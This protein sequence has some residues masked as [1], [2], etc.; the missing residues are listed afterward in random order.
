MRRLLKI[1]AI[2]AVVLVVAIGAI[3]VFLPTERISQ[4]AVDQVKSATG[5]DLMLSGGVSPS[6]Y[7]VLG[8]ETGAVTL[9]N[10]EW[11]S[12]PNMVS[13]SSAKIGVELMPLLSG[14][15]RITEIRLIDPIIDLEINEDGA[16]NW[17]FQPLEAAAEATVTETE[18][19]AEAD[20]EGGFVKDISLGET[21]IQNGAVNFTDRTSGQ[22]ISIAEINAAIALPAF[23]QEMTVSGSALWNGEETS[24][25]LK[26]ST[27]ATILAGAETEVSLTAGAA[28]VSVEFAGAF[29][30]PTASSPPE[31]AGTFKL[32]ASNPAA[33]AQWATGDA[34]PVG[35]AGLAD[36][37][38]NGEIAM[39]STVIA[40]KV[41]GGLTR[42]GRRATVDVSVQ[43]DAEW[44]TS[45]AFDVNAKAALDGLADASFIGKIAAPDGGAP[46]GS[47]N[48]VVNAPDIKGL[49][50]FAGAD[51][52]KMG[53][54]A[55]QSFQASGALTLANPSKIALDLKV[56]AIDAIT[57]SGTVSAD[58]AGTPSITANLDTGALDLTPY[59]TEGGQSTGGGE[60]GWSKTPID[61]SALGTVNGDFKIRAASVKAPQLT[62]GKSDIRAVLANGALQ[63]NIQELGLYG[64]GL[65]GD[66]ALD[67]RNDNAVKANVSAAT[68]RLLPMLKDVAG[69]EMV[70]G[71]G[72][73]N[74]NV[75]GG[76]QS[77]HDI[78]NSLDG[79]GG[80]KLTDGALVGYDLA[81]MIQNVKSAFGGG[82][83]N[84]AKTSFSE[85][86]AT[87]DIEN[88][89]MT[90]ADFAFLGPLIRIV[91]QGTVDL[92]G[93]LVNF[94]LTPK[95]VS[96]LKGQGGSLDDKGLSFPL[97]IKGPWSS[98]SIRPDLKAGIDSLLK[99][100]EGAVNAAKDIVKG[101]K[102]GGGVKGAV[103][104]LTGG[105]SGGVGGLLGGGNADGEAETA[106][107]DAV[108][109]VLKGLFGKK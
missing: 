95:A 93:Q 45:R 57:A 86:S 19:D 62:L 106:P 26:V 77:L 40:V 75:R 52:P 99:D 6:F 11:G 29:A 97:I 104:A 59:V 24:L 61:L 92:G 73:V 41:Q 27:L 72:A 103:E 49:A 65:K 89:V 96:S 100:P 5:R 71:L 53:P 48:F 63:L 60:P 16:A 69:M 91:G 36:L 82:A 54:N 37:D 80:M 68:V 88:G 90:N 8:V 81:A 70:E 38:L 66:I 12:A 47:G 32:S 87:F 43:G 39:D 101:V 64:G 23:D 22:N 74:I 21:T 17:E 94:R 84:D 42:D 13:A 102:D 15:V 51:L 9:S 18:Q 31:V 4:I 35:L 30:P 33:A 98:P 20:G 79:N 76:G 83:D 85:I 10:S 2:L 56:L 107:K 55:L 14:S 108:K 28:P 50:A 78:M 7:P 67:G 58:L 109:G 34:A 1:F 105:Q 25:D 44:A 3:I 46:N